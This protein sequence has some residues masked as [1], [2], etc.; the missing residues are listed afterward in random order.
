MTIR[1]SLIGIAFA[2]AAI[3]VVPLVAMQFTDEVNWS[4]FDFI[5]MGALLFGSGL[6]YVLI[7]RVV[8]SSAYR[9][10]VGVVV[11]TGFLLIW[12]NLAVGII[13]SENNPANQ[14]YAG[15]LVIGFFGAVIA[16][17]KPRGMAR[18]MWL[19][20]IAQALVP[21]IAMIIWR[22]SLDDAPG[23]IGV[24]VL[25]G[26]FATLF[27]FSALMFRRADATVAE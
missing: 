20:A 25:N 17:F 24:F 1:R 4:V 15:V 3:L 19:T 21:V 14:L 26:F 18:T 16:R 10:G 8:N 27:V 5:F 6:A 7:S 13:G 23:I 11:V 2:T 12:M 22:P 9:I